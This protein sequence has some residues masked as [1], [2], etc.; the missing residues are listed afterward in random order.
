MKRL[1]FGLLAAVT[2]L[3]ASARAAGNLGYPPDAFAIS[4]ASGTVANASAA[5]TL[6][7]TA[8]RQVFLCGFTIA[9]TGS[10]AAAVVAPTITGLTGGTHTFA[11]ASVAGATL[12]NPFVSVRYDLCIPASAAGTNIVV[13]LPALGAGNTNATVTAWGYIR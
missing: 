3:T 7:T 9:S 2:M 10:T 13:T 6:T 4:G 5:A 1:M 12:N 8:G 11:Y